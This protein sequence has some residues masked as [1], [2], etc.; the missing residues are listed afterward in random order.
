MD[1]ILIYDKETGNIEG[2]VNAES[3]DI[4]LSGNVSPVYFKGKTFDSEGNEVGESDVHL[5]DPDLG[6]LFTRNAF[7]SIQKGIVFL[8]TKSETDIKAEEIPDIFYPEH[9]IPYVVNGVESQ[10]TYIAQRR[11]RTSRTIDAAGKITEQNKT[12]K[13]ILQEHYSD[14]IAGFST[15]GL[16]EN[17]SELVSKIVSDYKVE[18]DSTTNAKRLVARG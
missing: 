3:I 11:V 7:P 13:K 4:F 9:Q 10:T 18:V 12:R 8:T 14:L 5:F 17:Q 1:T 6:F 15:E 2:A 16:P